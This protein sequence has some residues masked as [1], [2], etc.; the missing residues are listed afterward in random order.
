ML[1]NSKIVRRLELYS[2]INKVLFWEADN[3][4]NIYI[5]YFHLPY[6]P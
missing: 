6:F 3:S 5:E 2:E 1:E 4:E